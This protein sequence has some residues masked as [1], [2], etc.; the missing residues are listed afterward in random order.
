MHN[1]CYIS[2]WNDLFKCMCLSF[3]PP[4][5][6]QFDCRVSTVRSWEGNG[7]W[8]IWV[9]F[10]YIWL[11]P[12]LQKKLQRQV[13][14]KGTETHRIQ[15]NKVYSHPTFK[16]DHFLAVWQGIFLSLQCRRHPFDHFLEISVRGVFAFCRREWQ[17]QC[18]NGRRESLHHILWMRITPT[19]E[20]RP[21][22]FSF[23][24]TIDVHKLTV[25]AESHWFQI[26]ATCYF[27]FIRMFWKKRRICDNKIILSSIS[28]L[29]DRTVNSPSAA[30]WKHPYEMSCGNV[31]VWAVFRNLFVPLHWVPA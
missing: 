25:G 21:L 19:W 26:E 30:P 4:W 13:S 28:F 24:S 2:S 31:P 29:Q 11:C 3:I 9:P 16:I 27:L 5:Y 1:R 20:N 22:L 15:H 7:L 17:V 23:F 14:G 18:E 12:H 8:C 6:R 10:L